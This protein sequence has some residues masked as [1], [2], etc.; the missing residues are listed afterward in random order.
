MRADCKKYAKERIGEINYNNA[1]LRMEIIEYNST[2]NITIRLDNGY[3]RKAS[4]YNF[5]KGTIKTP[6]DRNSRGG[7]L[8]EGIYSYT[9]H[10]EA[11]GCWYS[12]LNRCF[13]EDCSEHYEKCLVW[14]DWLNFQNFAEWYEQHKY[15]FYGETLE[16]DK[17]L[18]CKGNTLYSPRTCLLLP[19]EL[20]CII[21]NCKKGRGCLPIGVT[22]S[23][24]KYGAQIHKDGRK[25]M[26]GRYDT[27]E[28]AFYVYKEAKENYIKEI[29]NRYKDVIPL[30]VYNA[31]CEW[32]I[33]I[34]D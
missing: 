8:G 14:K 24:G 13:A 19:H 27:V 34:T 12:L 23:H 10:R 7:Y 2:S 32:K 5:K 17:D 15:N 28:E 33:E 30:E 1:G 26:L 22:Y 18:K 9:K 3:T 21:L 6:Y 29:A 31:L 25:I 11:Y 16:L 20:N 4:Y